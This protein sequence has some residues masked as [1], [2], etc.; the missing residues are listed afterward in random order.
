MKSISIQYLMAESLL[1][2]SLFM[3][4]KLVEFLFVEF[5]NIGLVGSLKVEFY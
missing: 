3:K 2:K 4:S 1:G 5:T